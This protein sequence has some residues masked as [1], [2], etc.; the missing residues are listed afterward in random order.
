MRLYILV[1][2]LLAAAPAE[3]ARVAGIV[4]DSSG[5]P[6]PG[7]TVT[8]GTAS[9]VTGDDGQFEI[10]DATAGAEIRDRKSVV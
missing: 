4:V 1:F 10:P 5:A 3:A 7:A 6:V 2:C 8:V 9:V